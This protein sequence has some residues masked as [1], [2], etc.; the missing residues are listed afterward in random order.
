VAPLPASLACYLPLGLVLLA[1]PQPSG[2]EARKAEAEACFKGSV[3]P[4]VKTICSPCHQNRRP[5]RVSTCTG[6][7]PKD[8]SY[9]E[10]GFNGQH[11]SQALHQ[12][13]AEKIR[14]VAAIVQ[15]NVAQLAYMVKK[16]H[17]LRDAG[18][19]LLDNCIVMWGSGLEDGMHHGRKNLPF[20][21]AG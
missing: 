20:I 7:T 3:T 14:K 13:S 19:A 18:G 15:F 12:G 10:P 17:I 21:L 11:Y 8:V 2:L 1:C 16:M 9:P 4:V 6:A 5:T